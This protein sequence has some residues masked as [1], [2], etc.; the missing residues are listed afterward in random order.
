LSGGDID[1]ERIGA[2]RRRQDIADFFA[3]SR[4]APFIANGVF[5]ITGESLR[6]IQDR[7]LPG[8]A[9]STRVPLYTSTAGWVA[10]DVQ[11]G[12]PIGERWRVGGGIGNL[13]DKNYRLHGSG[14]DSPGWNAFANLR[15]TF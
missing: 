12:L 14:L 6:Q 2:S 1:D 8:V 5:T 10:L 13:L 7:V 11:G 15:Y 3:G 9:D 4:I